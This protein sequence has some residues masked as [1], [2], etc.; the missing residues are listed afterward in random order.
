M[1]LHGGNILCVSPHLRLIS[2]TRDSR[3]ACEN[4]QCI[5]EHNETSIKLSS[6][7]LNRKFAHRKCMELLKFRFCVFVPASIV[8]IMYYWFKFKC[9]QHTGMRWMG[10]C[11]IATPPLPPAQPPTCVNSICYWHIECGLRYRS[12]TER[13]THPIKWKL[14]VEI[15]F[16]RFGSRNVQTLQKA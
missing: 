12:T 11:C 10:E 14:P 13:R 1:R 3:R 7:N 5:F 6:H 8:K 2:R 16:V 4:I 9:R 15:H